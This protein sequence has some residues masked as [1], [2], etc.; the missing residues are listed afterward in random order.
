MKR[1]RGPLR[2]PTPLRT[3]PR[4]SV[5][6]PWRRKG[7]ESLKLADRRIDMMAGRGNAVRRPHCF[8]KEIP[9]PGKGKSTRRSAKSAGHKRSA[10][11]AKPKKSKRSPKKTGAERAKSIKQMKQVLIERLETL[12][13]GMEHALGGYQ[14]LG[15][16]A[17][18]AGRGD[19]SDLAADSLDG[20]TALQLAESGASEIAQIAKAMSK[21]E[22]GDY[23]K[24]EVCGEDIPWSRLKAVPYATTCI[25]CKRLQEI[26]GS[27]TANASGWSAVDDLADLA[28]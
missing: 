16:A 13:G 9:M 27:S 12:Q 14:D 3:A 23:G 22:D 25:E 17:G 2:S 11:A 20:D 1:G 10:E 15:G 6:R 18:K 4:N 26:K 21:M 5:R 7:D 28:E 8:Q 19:V 24:C